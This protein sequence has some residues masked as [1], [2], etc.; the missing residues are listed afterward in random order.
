[1]TSVLWILRAP[2]SWYPPAP[3]ALIHRSSLI[4][5][6]C[7]FHGDIS[8]RTEYSKVSLSLCIMSG[9]GSLYLSP[10]AAGESLSDDGWERHWPAF[11]AGA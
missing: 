6:G 9:C 10:S 7:G 11:L 1:M 2:F 3:L 4:L 5:G 8:S